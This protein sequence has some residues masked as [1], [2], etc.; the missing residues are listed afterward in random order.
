VDFTKKEVEQ[1]VTKP[2]SVSWSASWSLK[3]GWVLADI[4][5]AGPGA[6]PDTRISGNSAS[7]TCYVD[8]EPNRGYHVNVIVIFKKTQ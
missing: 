8:A 1:R 2:I 7:G 4:G 3:P 5:K 6:C